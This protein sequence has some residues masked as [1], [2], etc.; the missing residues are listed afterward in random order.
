MT[1]DKKIFSYDTLSKYRNVLMGLQ[2]ILIIVFHFTEDAYYQRD[3]R[4]IYLFYNYVRSSGV[5]MFL[6]MSGIGL[7]FSWKRKPDVKKFYIKRFSRI[8]IPYLI[9]AI[10]AWI[11][12][13][14]FC[15]NIGWLA[16]LQD[17][18]F[19]TFFTEGTRWFWYILMAAF[20]YWIFPYIFLIIE[21]ASDDISSKMRIL[22][23]CITST[24]LVTL[25]QLYNDELYKCTSI[26]ITR[27]PAFLVGVLVGKAVYEKKQV[28]KSHIY[29]MVVL[30]IIIAWPLQMI[31]S[32]II[33]VYSL[34]FLN[35]SFSLLFV[36]VLV[37]WSERENLILNRLYNLTVN[38]LGSLGKYTLELYLIHVM[39]RKVMKAIGYPTYQLSNE[40]TLIV[41]SIVLSIIV[42]KVSGYF[43]RCIKNG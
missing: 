33:G 12:M 38:I 24:V 23:L 28:P 4:I 11:W 2:I 40:L 22:L 16:V 20:C 26:A 17:L 42:N 35:Y 10:P 13:D 3:S 14:I 9:V 5:D 43:I 41:L 27:I 8:F 34:A 6:L 7:Y 31:T 19:L 21:S 15:Q 25:L 32:K 39:I 37:Y 29:V 18:F 36:C 1:Q 30:A